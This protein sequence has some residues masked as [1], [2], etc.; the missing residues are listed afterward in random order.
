VKKYTKDINQKNYFG[1][2]L[3]KDNKKNKK[4]QKEM[5][6]QRDKYGFDNGEIFNLDK[7]FAKWVHKRLKRFIKVNMGHPAE[8][9]EEEW[10]IILHKMLNGFKIYLKLDDYAFEKSEEYFLLKKEKSDE[11]FELFS[12]WHRDLWY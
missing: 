5:R 7:T 4:Y 8:L 9:T 11:A 12:K 2:V 10:D 6:K 1:F 3:D